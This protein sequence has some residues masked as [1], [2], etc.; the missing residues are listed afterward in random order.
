MRCLIAIAKR[1]PPVPCNNAGRSLCHGGFELN[2]SFSQ[3]KPVPAKSG[4]TFPGMQRYVIAKQ[5][6]E[7]ETRHQTSQSALLARACMR[8]RA[9]HCRKLQLAIPPE[10]TFMVTQKLNGWPWVMQCPNPQRQAAEAFF[11]V[12]PD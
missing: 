8:W 11:S 1:K 9:S 6:Q 12:Q 10:E 4:Q 5:Q 2:V 7:H 3:A